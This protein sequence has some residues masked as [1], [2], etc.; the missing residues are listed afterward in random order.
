[1]SSRKMMLDATA[2]PSAI[3]AVTV[4]NAFALSIAVYAM[5]N[6]SGSHV[7]WAAMFGMAIRVH[8]IAQEMTG[9]EASILEGVMTFGL[10]YTVYVANDPRRSPL[11]AIGPL[12]I[13]F[14]VGAN[15]LASGPYMGGSMN[16]TYSFGSALVGGVSR[17]MSQC[18]RIRAIYVRVNV[19]GSALVGGSFKNHIVYWVGPLIGAALASILYD[20]VVFPVQVPSIAN[21]VGV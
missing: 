8:G 21:G 17:T 4:A 18:I 7:N 19:P 11:G 13:K 10:F 9:F 16:P 1:M 12:A 2:D 5:A 15:V 6:I 14:I 20:N 3:V